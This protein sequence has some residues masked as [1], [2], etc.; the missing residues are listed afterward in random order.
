MGKDIQRNIALWGVVTD[1]E[2]QEIIKDWES[3][4]IPL[5]KLN[6]DNPFRKL[7]RSEW[8]EEMIQSYTETMKK[9][10]NSGT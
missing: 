7:P 4:N 5:Y 3:K 1:E 2:V 8:T 9:W 6:P 10:E